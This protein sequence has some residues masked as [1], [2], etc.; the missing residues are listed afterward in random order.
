MNEQTPPTKEPLSILLVDADENVLNA[1]RSLFQ[2]EQFQVLTATSG[3][4]GLDILKRAENI[5][6]ILSAQ[7]MMGMTGVAF[8][9]MAGELAPDTP[10]MIL[11]EHRDANAAIDAINH[12]GVNRFLMKPWDGPELLQA[13]RE[14]V[15]RY[16]LIQENHRLNNLVRL[17]RDE[18]A[19]WN[20]NLKKRFLQQAATMR[21]QLTEAR[22]QNGNTQKVGPIIIARFVDL[23]DQCYGRVSQHSHIVA[24]LA[25][26]IAETLKLP[27]P[28]CEEIRDAALLH[29]LGKVGMS[30]RLLSRGRKIM[31]YDELKEYRTH[32]IRG[33]SI[34]EKV[35]ELREIGILIRHH[36]E[37]FD[38]KGFPDGLAGEQ[39]PL[40]SR[41]IALADCAEN[42]FSHHGSHKA[43]YAVS[44][45]IA[46]E[47]GR[48]F[49]PALA[50]AANIAVSQVLR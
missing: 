45:L 30:D 25:E 19:E 37:S 49:D 31:T 42:S 26:S 14:G 10:R 7:Q 12:G 5:G 13:V 48:L 46:G 18:L 32:S 50:S 43:K 21:Q 8:L 38:G 9:K 40:G 41:I 22:R 33:P 29:D 39:I 1:L 2:E 4:E 34:L 16:L 23:L 20:A 47:M 17:Q 44:K 27:Q 35:E 3:Q 24:A 6:L 36:H 15:Q 11:T 28:L